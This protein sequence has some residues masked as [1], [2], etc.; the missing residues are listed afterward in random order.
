[1]GYKVVRNADANQPDVVEIVCDTIAEVADLPTTFGI[2]SD[3][4]VL[5]DSLVYMLGTDKVWHEL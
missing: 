5:E 2:G 4:I 1:M 3:C